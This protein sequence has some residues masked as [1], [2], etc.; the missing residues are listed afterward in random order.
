LKTTKPSSSSKA[1][2]SSREQYLY[3]TTRGRKTGLA[4]E[5]E[6]WFTELGGCYYVI[7]EYSTSQWIRNLQACPD[8]EFR[9]AGQSHLAHARVI[10]TD[11]DPDLSRTVQQASRDKYGWGDG[12]VVELMP[13]FE[14]KDPTSAD[15]SGT[16]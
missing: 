14:T 3:L 6:I 16:E 12:V 13:T 10:T 4:R 5:I 8:V 15:S 1:S 9:V 11:S 7:A 2:S